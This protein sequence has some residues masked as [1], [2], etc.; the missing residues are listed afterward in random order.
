LNSSGTD[1]DEKH[2]THPISN[3]FPTIDAAVAEATRIGALVP[4]QV[5][6]PW[7]PVGYRLSK[8]ATRTILCSSSRI[9]L[10]AI[11]GYS[12]ILATGADIPAAVEQHVTENHFAPEDFEA[13]I[14]QA[15]T[16]NDT[17]R[18][19]LALLREPP[20]PGRTAIPYLGDL[21]IYETNSQRVTRS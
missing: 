1:P 4:L 15:A 18:Q 8:V 2:A 21:Y 7:K 10:N 20:L 12:E 6:F 16:R 9:P 13:F 5:A 19:V 14:V 11:I 17:M 3:P